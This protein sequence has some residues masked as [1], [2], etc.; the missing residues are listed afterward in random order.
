MNSCKY[1]FTE[2]S[3]RGQTC[4]APLLATCDRSEPSKPTEFRGI[5]GTKKNPQKMMMHPEADEQS[6]FCFWHQRKHNADKIG[7]ES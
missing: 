1:K 4:G 7:K 5:G 6:D 2:G 3:S